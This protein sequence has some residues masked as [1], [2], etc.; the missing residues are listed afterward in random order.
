MGVTILG[1]VA[2]VGTTVGFGV[3]G[4]WW[5]RLAAGVGTVVVLVVVV[6]LG[7]SQ[8][9]RGVVARVADWLTGEHR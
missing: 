3:S 9:D 4:P 8:G 1:V 5:M 6:K 7:T 2:S